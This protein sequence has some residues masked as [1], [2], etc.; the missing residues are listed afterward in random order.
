MTSKDVFASAKS[1]FLACAMILA[2]IGGLVADDEAGPKAIPTK[3]AFKPSLSTWAAPLFTIGKMEPP[4][5]KDLRRRNL[6]IF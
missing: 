3:A 5:D 2:S 4:M 1:A 6:P